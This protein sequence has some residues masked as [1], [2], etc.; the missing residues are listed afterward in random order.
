MCAL[1]VLVFW[2]SRRLEFDAKVALLLTAI[3]LSAPYLWYYEAA[4]TAAIGLF[5]VRAGILGRHPAHL[6]LL[7]VLWIGAGWQSWN[8]F[9]HLVDDRYLGAV[10]VTP[11]L[12]ICFVLCWMHYAAAHRG[13][14]RSA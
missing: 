8:V 2:R 6:A 4:M 5:L 7:A 14:P 13:L 9:L 12:G 1:S 10:V 3:L 11:A